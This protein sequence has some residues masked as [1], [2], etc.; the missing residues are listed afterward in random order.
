MPPPLCTPLPRL[1]PTGSSSSP[2]KPWVPHKYPELRPC[3]QLPARPAEMLS[4]FFPLK[5][6]P[7][8]VAKHRLPVSPAGTRVFLSFPR[9]TLAQSL[10][11]ERGRSKRQGQHPGG[12]CLGD[13]I[14]HFGNWALIVNILA[15][16]AGRTQLFKLW[17]FLF[18]KWCFTKR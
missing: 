7:P 15:A 12:V 4:L 9:A 14:L 18:I 2:P 8:C 11:L 1:V 5:P 10:D 16:A 13:F 6:G 3:L 17:G